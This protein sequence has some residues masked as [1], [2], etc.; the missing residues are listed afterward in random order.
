MLSSPSGG[1]RDC[2]VYRNK[3]CSDSDTGAERIRWFCMAGKKSCSL[4]ENCCTPIFPFLKNLIWP[5]FELIFL[6][7]LSREHHLTLFTIEAEES[8]KDVIIIS[9]VGRVGVPLLPLPPSSFSSL[10]D[11]FMSSLFFL[12]LTFPFPYPLDVFHVVALK[13]DTVTEW[14]YSSGRMS[15]VGWWL[16]LWL[17]VLNVSFILSLRSHCTN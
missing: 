17:C 1:G 8:S 16:I 12:P 14:E 6:S 5:S 7:A 13:W 10:G 4:K 9:F 3:G 2:L 15:V 11:G